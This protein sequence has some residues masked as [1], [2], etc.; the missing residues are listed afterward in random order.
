MKDV[1]GVLIKK[2]KD[3]TFS[4]RCLSAVF[5]DV[6]YRQEDLDEDTVE[7]IWSFKQ[8]LHCLTIRQPTPRLDFI[9]APEHITRTYPAGTQHGVSSKYVFTHTP[10]L[11][12]GAWEECANINTK[13]IAMFDENQWWYVLDVQPQYNQSTLLPLTTF[14]LAQSLVS[15]MRSNIPF[16]KNEPVDAVIASIHED[17]VDFS[18]WDGSSE[19]MIDALMCVLELPQ[20]LWAKI[21]LDIHNQDFMDVLRKIPKVDAFLT[22]KAIDTEM[23]FVEKRHANARKM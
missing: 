11:S 14:V 6:F 5:I 3:G 1:C 13:Q 17:F 20:D 19:D 10:A 8:D 2:N 21:N 9:G 18:G 12:D 22:K 16:Y 7:W 23:G 15:D 4:P